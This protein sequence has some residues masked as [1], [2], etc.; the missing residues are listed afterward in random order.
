MD[1]FRA[2][3]I[4]KEL[5]GKKIGNWVIVDYLNNG[6]SAVVLKA[7]RKGEEAAIKV[8]DPDLVERFGR[9]TQL[10][11]VR[12][13]MVLIGKKHPNLI[14]IK[15]GGECKKTG[16]IFVAM[17][18]LETKNLSQV[19]RDLPRNRI[20]PLIRQVA[21][22][23][24]FLEDNGLAHRDIKPEN[25]AISDDFE[26]AILLDLG[27]LRPVGLS[28]ITDEN[29]KRVFVGTLRYSP[30]ELLYREEEDSPEGWRAI[31]FYQLG[32]VLHDMIMRRPI[33]HN[34][35]EPYAKLV[36]A[37]REEIPEIKADDVESDLILLAKSCLVK[38]PERRLSMISWDQFLK[39]QLTRRSCDSYRERIRKRRALIGAQQ[40]KKELVLEEERKYKR[41]LE[42][43]RMVNSIK[44]MI[45]TACID[46]RDC[47]PPFEIN[48]RIEADDNNASILVCFRPS[49]QHHLFVAVTLVVLISL[50]DEHE[51]ILDLRFMALASDDC[52][53]DAGYDNFK[54]KR[55]FVG[56][57][58]HDII[59][60]K[61]ALLLLALIDRG[62][63]LEKEQVV[64][65][66]RK[67]DG[68]L[69]QPVQLTL[70]VENLEEASE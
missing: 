65:K 8:F 23:A 66:Y 27:V 35:C 37:V 46:D 21:S 60:I 49:N 59:K 45:R 26:Q 36:D 29:E 67:N 19:L 12:R 42:L 31:T 10:T 30:P 64:N 48:H 50:I 9:E 13:E 33:F 61:I 1:D 47:F 54:T 7:S 34:F 38:N 32:A 17:A 22:A 15:D 69:L 55:F 6:K 70:D 11:R 43:E 40:E 52:I 2:K 57:F 18:Y 68:N 16:Y 3:R 39:A 5:K 56:P 63:E 51:V 4:A 28:E 20:F 41:F 62:Q 44:E 53:R 24:K 14:E 58:E 25:I